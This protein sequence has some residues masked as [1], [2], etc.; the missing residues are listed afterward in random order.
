[1]NNELVKQLLNYYKENEEDF[2]D[3]IEELDS[4]YGCLYENRIFQMEELNE[5]FRDI[6]PNVILRR[7]FYGYD[8]AVNEDDQYHPFNPNRQ[9]FYFNVYGNLVSINKK[10]Y[11]DYLNED[12]IQDIIDN[13]AYLSLSKGVQNLIDNYENESE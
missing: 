1:M 6:K 4:W 7:A 3:D 11:S 5:F 12:F 2:I 13:K 8:E 10:D 9:Y